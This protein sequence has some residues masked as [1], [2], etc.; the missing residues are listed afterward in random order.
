MDTLTPESG[1]HEA[2]L[3]TVRL[4]RQ[5]CDDLLAM[6]P[7]ADLITA[8][9]RLRLASH[10]IVSAAVTAAILAGQEWNTVAAALNMPVE[11]AKGR[12]VV[13]D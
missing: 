4:A 9:R 8:A 11:I 1:A 5:Q 10:D 6:T 3:T 12:Y 13:G 2:F 7:S